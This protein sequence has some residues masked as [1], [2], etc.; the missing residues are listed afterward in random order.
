M[1]TAIP[2]NEDRIANHFSKAVNFLFIN[3][4]GEEVSRHANPLHS[5]HCTGKKDLLDL[6]I[7][8][9]AERIVV[10][11][12]GKQMLG[13][14][15]AH[16]LAVFQTDSGRRNT[17]ELANPEATGLIILTESGQGRSSLNYEAKQKEDGCRHHKKAISK[18]GHCCQQ[19]TNDQGT[20]ERHHHKGCH[21]T[22][23]RE[24][25]RCGHGKSRG[26]HCCRNTSV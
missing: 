16:R 17:I 4:Q 25:D 1:I 9:R 19:R 6:L 20:Q 21:N 22:H 3:E 23:N 14:L 26:R 7:Q 10:R 18:Q 24:H 5:T 2:M 15:L 8:Q 11:N 13:K 12:I